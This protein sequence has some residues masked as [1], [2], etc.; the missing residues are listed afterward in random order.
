M[1]VG[2]VNV[3]GSPWDACES[4]RNL[5]FFNLAVLQPYSLTAVSPILRQ[6]A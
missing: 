1:A 2:Y 5:F 4:N 6:P 3:V